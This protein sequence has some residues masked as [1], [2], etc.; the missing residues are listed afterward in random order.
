[1]EMVCARMESVAATQAMVVIIVQDDC[2]SRIY[3]ERFAV[4]MVNVLARINVSA[5]MDIMAQTVVFLHAKL[6][7]VY[8]HFST[9]YA[10]VTV[11]VMRVNVHVI[12]VIMALTA[13]TSGV[14]RNSL[15]C[16]DLCVMVMVTA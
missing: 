10:V 5:G 11:L 15:T 1:M 16:L 13:Q 3:L 4:E 6:K 9:L 7:E 8:Y 14:K 12:P 2:A